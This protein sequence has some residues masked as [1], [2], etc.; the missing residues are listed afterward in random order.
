MDLKV[1]IYIKFD[2]ITKLMT[3]KVSVITRLEGN[4]LNSTVK[5]PIPGWDPL[6]TNL[7]HMLLVKLIPVVSEN[8]TLA[9]LYLDCQKVF[10]S[11]AIIPGLL[12][13]FLTDKIS[14]VSEETC[15]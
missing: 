15:D 3:R 8:L 6:R 4:E 14:I 11:R 7:D 10:S 12:D 2:I 9:D 5:I 13:E 1:T